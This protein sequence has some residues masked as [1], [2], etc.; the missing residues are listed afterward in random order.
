ME[1]EQT[2]VLDVNAKSQQ[3]VF[4]LI[5]QEAV[6]QGYGDNQESILNGLKTREQ[7]GTT[8]MMDGFAIPHAKSEAILKA[9]LIILKL[10]QGIEWDS[11]DGKPTEFIIS[12]LIPDEEKGTTHLKIL[13]KVAR[14]LMKEDAKKDLK[15]AESAEK[16]ETV[17][18]KYISE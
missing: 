17:L 15:K 7:E 12:L 9:S 18:N 3:E 6:K 14:L 11:M 4:M 5:A 8:G 10:T 16:I 2:V 13:S 1:I